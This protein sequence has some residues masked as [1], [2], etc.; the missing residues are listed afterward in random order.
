LEHRNEY[1]VDGAT[2]NHVFDHKSKTPSEEI[3]SPTTG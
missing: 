2:M 1:F 3:R